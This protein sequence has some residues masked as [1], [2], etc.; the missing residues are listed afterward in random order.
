MKNA[1]TPAM[2]SEAEISNNNEAWAFQIDDN[3]KFK[4]PGLTKREMFAMHALPSAIKWLGSGVGRGE[5]DDWSFEDAASHA[6]IA[7]DA[8]LK[9]LE[10]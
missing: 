8:L 3:S 2:P 1:D 10:K 4:F 9:E 5:W 7:A 6:V